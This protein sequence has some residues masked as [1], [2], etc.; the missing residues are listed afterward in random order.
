MPT[1]RNR[2][3]TTSGETTEIV[4]NL[5]KFT[6]ICCCKKPEDYT[7]IPEIAL[8]SLLMAL[9]TAQSIQKKCISA[10]AD[11]FLTLLPAAAV[12]L[13]LVY[14]PL[15]IIYSKNTVMWASIMF[16]CTWLARLILNWLER[17]D[18]RKLY[19]S[20]G[21]EVTRA[22]AISDS[23]NLEKAVSDQ[24]LYY[25]FKRNHLV[26]SSVSLVLGYTVNFTAMA[27]AL[28]AFSLR[29][30][31]FELGFKTL[32]VRAWSAL[33]ENFQAECGIKPPY[34]FS[35]NTTLLGG[36]NLREPINTISP[37]TSDGSMVNVDL[38]N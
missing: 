3:P 19:N 10:P 18:F 16:A 38:E 1:K 21:D 13:T 4:H 28:Y 23:E 2:R 12:A 11:S 26:S 31:F 25:M 7:K 15:D 17:R 32:T 27:I 35:N 24:R 20:D 33:V 8:L 34:I 22:I 36:A 37:V 14:A 30:I 5:S 9:F 29:E 6:L